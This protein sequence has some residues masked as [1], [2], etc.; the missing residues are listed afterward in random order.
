MES[1]TH[2]SKV[3]NLFYLVLHVLF[4]RNH[5]DQKNINRR[6]VFH[7]LSETRIALQVIYWKVFPGETGKGGRRE[8]RAGQ[9]SNQGL[10]AGQVLGTD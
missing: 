8:D 5:K 1:R 9:Q 4:G 10:D 6:F 3:L 2:Y 7:Q